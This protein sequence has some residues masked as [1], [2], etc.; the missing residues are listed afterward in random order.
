MDVH[1]LP[2]GSQSETK[3][4]IMFDYVPL[5]VP[6]NCDTSTKLIASKKCHNHKSAALI[7]TFLCRPKVW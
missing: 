5:C 2:T 6:Y 1:F 3:P 7:V 4:Y